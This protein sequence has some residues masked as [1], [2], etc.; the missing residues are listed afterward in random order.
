MAVVRIGECDLQ[1]C[2]QCGGLWVEQSAFQHVCEQK[3][4]QQ[5]VLGMATPVSDALAGKSKEVSRLYIPCPECGNLMNRMNFAG[6]SGVIIDWCRQHGS[7]FDHQELRQIVTFIREGGLRKS[8]EREIEKVQEETR[9]L[10]QQERD[11]AAKGIRQGET[12]QVGG[13]W[14]DDHQ[15]L[16]DIL[17]AI[18]KGLPEKH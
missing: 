16:S 15:L 11:L 5:A 14:K 7:W 2:Q 4:E 8:R 10:R 12:I 18:W 13:N 6:C 9:R 1:E 17:S 3:D